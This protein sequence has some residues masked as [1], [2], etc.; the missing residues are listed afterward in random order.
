MALTG[1][2]GS[3]GGGGPESWILI[4]VT[5]V[6]PHAHSARGPTLFTQEGVESPYGQLRVGT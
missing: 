1:A 4:R 2:A 3:E 6:V 5:A